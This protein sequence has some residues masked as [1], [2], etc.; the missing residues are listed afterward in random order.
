[1]PPVKTSL[2]AAPAPSFPLLSKSRLA[3]RYG[4]T[5]S[6]V[7]K[8]MSEGKVPFYRLSSRVVRFDPLQCDMR[9]L[10]RYMPGR[11]EVSRRTV[12][13]HDHPYQIPLDLGE[14]PPPPEKRT[15]L[16]TL[17]RTRPVWARLLGVGK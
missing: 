13:L 7:E 8:W 1:M 16:M 14:L 4:V 5:V 10:A 15:T 6:C 12:K 3:R 17:P 2:P 11:S 9:L